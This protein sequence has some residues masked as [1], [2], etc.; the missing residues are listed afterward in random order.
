MAVKRLGYSLIKFEAE[1]DSSK[2]GNVFWQEIRFGSRTLALGAVIE[3]G[4]NDQFRYFPRSV[5]NLIAKH[6]SETLSRSAIV[7]FEEALKK[8]NRLI[9]KLLE[10]P[11]LKIAGGVLLLDGNELHFSGFGAISFSL[12]RE[13]QLV[14]L[15][16]RKADAVDS[17]S[18]VSSGQLKNGEW[19]I[20]AEDSTLKLLKNLPETGWQIDGISGLSELIKLK[21]SN[22]EINFGPA[23]A[24]HFQSDQPFEEEVIYP[25]IL[26]EEVLEVVDTNA[27][28]I[29]QEQ[30][31]N[32]LRPQLE[33]LK[34]AWS[35]LN[36]KLRRPRSLATSAPDSKKKLPL[37]TQPSYRRWLRPSILVG[38]ALIILI[39][40]GVFQL[41]KRFSAAKNPISQTT[42][43]DTLKQTPAEQLEQFLSDDLTLS[44]YQELSEDQKLELNRLTETI[45]LEIYPLDRL[46]SELPATITNLDVGGSSLFVLDQNGQVWKMI[47]D[48]PNKLEMSQPIAQPSSLTALSTEKAISG[49]QIGNLWLLDG[50]ATQPINLTL[51][52]NLASSQKL[53]SDFSSNL[54]IY[55][56]ENQSI[57][58]ISNF[59]KDI[60]SPVVY[61]KLSSLGLNDIVGWAINGDIL[62]IDQSGKVNLIHNKKKTELPL[63]FELDRQ[64]K[65]I[66]AE[67]FDGFAVVAGRFLNHYSLS[68]QLKKKILILAEQPIMAASFDSSNTS[69]YLSIGN[70][71]HQLSL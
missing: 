30:K 65:I 14:S 53:L 25:V 68:G 56:Q 5:V 45:K 66:A 17:F 12:Y 41:T 48:T 39:A 37:I 64:P 32:P 35:S 61:L 67:K 54:Y 38:L 7:A 3:V 55:N 26:A 22:Q 6:F 13:G 49:D 15:S 29:F 36:L 63:S 4:Q 40:L 70:Q 43:F 33:L 11:E 21:I 28:P 42:F 23:L 16:D 47:N 69:I 27:S 46:V 2:P 24:L 58:R 50:S 19:F 60:G 18:S 51:P 8:A 59:Q 44:K 9:S 71:L 34:R 1:F 62:V 20:I 10:K 57:Y 31:A 52:Q